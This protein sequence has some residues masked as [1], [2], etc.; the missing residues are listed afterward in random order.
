MFRATQPRHRALLMSNSP[1]RSSSISGGCRK[2]AAHHFN[3]LPKDDEAEEQTAVQISIR[4]EPDEECGVTSDASELKDNEDRFT[5][6]EKESISKGMSSAGDTN[7]SGANILPPCDVKGQAEYKAN[8][9]EYKANQDENKANEMSKIKS[10]LEKDL[11]ARIMLEHEGGTGSSV[12][13]M[14]FEATP[15]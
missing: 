7:G 3:K 10:I 1:E 6:R 14:H 11:I 9:D 13:V 4:A 2:Q 8:E 5:S 12:N 15:V